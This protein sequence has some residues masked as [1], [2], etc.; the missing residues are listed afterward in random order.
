MCSSKLQ[1]RCALSQLQSDYKGLLGADIPL[2]DLGYSSLEYFLDIPDVISLRGTMNEK[3]HLAREGFNLIHIAKLISKQKTSKSGSRKPAIISRKKKNAINTASKNQKSSHAYFKNSLAN[4][5]KKTH[6]QCSKFVQLNPEKQK[7]KNTVSIQLRSVVQSCKGGVPLSRLDK[8]YR[9][10][11]GISI[12]FKDLGSDSLEDFIRSIPDVIYLKKNA[13]GQIVALGVTDTS[14][15]HLFG[16]ISKRKSSK[17]SVVKHCEILPYEYQNNSFSVICCFLIAVNSDIV[18]ADLCTILH[19]HFILLETSNLEIFKK[20]ILLFTGF[21][22]SEESKEWK[23]KMN[24]LS[25][26][27]KKMLTRSLKYLSIPHSDDDEDKVL[28]NKLLMGLKF[29]AKVSGKSIF[30][31]KL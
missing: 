9:A 21:P 29:Y 25:K 28:K 31:D 14:T 2:K 4:T 15:A 7:L 10:F 6:E 18:T 17:I 5:R 24:C 12:P 26:L 3:V 13:N 23:I 20:D 16:Q 11:I 22:I 19:L 1:R 8:D 27:P 30:C